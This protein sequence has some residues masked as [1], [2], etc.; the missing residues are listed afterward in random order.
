[1]FRNAYKPGDSVPEHSL[2]WVHHYQH[3]MP[4]VCRAAI[5]KV[6]PECTQCGSRVRFEPASPD[7]E[8]K[9]MR[10]A[11]DVDFKPAPR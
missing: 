6:F 7:A 2:F 8:P 9:A 4:H 10:L 3:R 1:M 11:D 5:F